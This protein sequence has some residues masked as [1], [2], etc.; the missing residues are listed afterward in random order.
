VGLSA[1]VSTFKVFRLVLSQVLYLMFLN[2]TVLNLLHVSVT[3]SLIFSDRSIAPTFSVSGYVKNALNNAVIPGATV[4][5]SNGAQTTCD[6]NGKYSFPSLT[7]GQ[8]NITAQT[9]GFINSQIS[10]DLSQDIQGKSID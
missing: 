4:T 7:M 6:S 9:N 3:F 5:A 8:Y 1:L 10:V 2:G